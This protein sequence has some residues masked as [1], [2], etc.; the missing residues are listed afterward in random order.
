MDF[1]E[2]LQM[3][4]A[5]VVRDETVSLERRLKEM[6]RKVNAYAVGNLASAIPDTLPRFWVSVRRP[7]N[8]EKPNHLLHAIKALRSVLPMGLKESK[9][10]FELGGRAGPMSRN[11]ANELYQTLTSY[12]YNAT[13]EDR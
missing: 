10:L 3:L 11:A 2:Q 13:I 6:E 5:R 1:A 8:G 9:E 7:Y 4:I 12:G